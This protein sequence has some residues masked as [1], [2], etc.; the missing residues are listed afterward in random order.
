MTE[1]VFGVI[2]NPVEHSLS[3]AMHNAAF[4]ELDTEARYHAFWVENVGPAV[5]GATALG[6]GGLNVTIP[7]KLA[8][9]E[10][11][12]SLSDDAEVIGAVNTLQ[13]DD[14]NVFGHNTDAEGARRALLAEIDDLGGART[15]VIG[16]GGAARAIVTAL[17][18]EGCQITVMNRTV[19]RAAE[20]AAL[21]RSLG[22]GADYES[23]DEKGTVGNFDLVVNA[24]SVGMGTDESLLDRE[25]LRGASYVFDA[26]YRPVRTRLLQEAEAAGAKPIDGVGMLVHQG[27]ESLRVWTGKEPPLEVMERAV[28][29][30]LE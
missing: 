7:H 15:A 22:A 4:G 19:A 3:P 8:V 17:A 21:A 28:R 12:E 5:E 20:L 10:H 24:T 2:G 27:A 9:M 25:D 26:V 14:G 29:G 23:L 11:C 30:E 16:A 6:F 18:R 13:F 1:S